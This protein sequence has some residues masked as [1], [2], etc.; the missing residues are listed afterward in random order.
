MEERS[1]SELARNEM[2]NHDTMRSDTLRS[3]SLDRGVGTHGGASGAP[4]DQ[5]HLASDSMDRI[6]VREGE[7]LVLLRIYDIDWFQQVGSEVHAHVGNKSYP[8]GSSLLRLERELNSDWF[9]RASDSAI[10]NLDRIRMIEPASFAS[11]MIT[12]ENGTEILLLPAYWPRFEQMI[13][14]IR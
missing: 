11:H 8:A 13:Q 3:G 14:T 12:I 10:V 7:R 5:D 4:I 1:M 6:A 2:M 9:L